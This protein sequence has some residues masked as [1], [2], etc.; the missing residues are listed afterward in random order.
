MSSE[1]R[2]NILSLF[3]TL[4]ISVPYFIYILDRY[5]SETF[6]TEEEIK[7]WA[8]ALLVL[9][10]I[11][12]VAEILVHIAFAIVHAIVTGEEELPEVTDERDEIIDLK[13]N[14]NAYYFMSIGIL[15]TA[16]VAALGGSVALLFITLMVAG[17][18]SELVSVMSQIF[19]YRRGV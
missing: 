14:R 13:A 11:R 7:F 16:V 15:S 8:I 2:D 12:I 18:F 9:I 5:N 4:V 10:P 6:T 3:T 19:Y 1:E 17:F